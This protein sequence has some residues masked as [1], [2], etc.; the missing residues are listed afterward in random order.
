VD[1]NLTAK[2]PSA[3]PARVSVTLDDETVLGGAED[4]PRGNPENPVSTALLEEKF[5]S[6][7]SSRAGPD[8]ARRALDA[9][10]SVA[11]WRD[12]STVFRDLL[13]HSLSQSA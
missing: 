5:T 7:V 6:L 1:E 13:R 4:Y 11:S 12:V 3:W 10:R 2:Y 9:V 8:V